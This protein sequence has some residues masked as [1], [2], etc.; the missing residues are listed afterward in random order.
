MKKQIVSLLLALVLV[1]SF[2]AVAAADVVYAGCVHHDHDADCGGLL[3]NCTYICDDCVAVAQALI[4]ALP[5]MSEIGDA[6]RAEVEQQMDAIHRALLP[7][8]DAAQMSMDMQ[9][10]ADAAFVLCT[11]PNFFGFA[12][13]K[14]YEVVDAN[15]PAPTISFLDENGVAATMYTASFQPLTAAELIPN[16]D[17]AYFYLPVGTYTVQEEVAGEWYMQLFVNGQPVQTVSGEEGMG[18]GVMVVNTYAPQHQ[19]T[20]EPGEGSGYMQP[21][22]VG[23]DEEYKYTLPACTF[24][25]PDGY[26]FKAWKV[27]GGSYN[28]DELAA[29][30][31]LE[32]I[33]FDITLTAQW[34][35]KG[36]SG[37]DDA[38]GGKP[39]KRYE[40]R[41]EEPVD[42]DV[43]VKSS[44]SYDSGV[45]IKPAPH[46]GFA[47]DEVTVT[48]ADGDRVPVTQRADG[49]YS[50]S[51]PRSS[52]TVSVSFAPLGEAVEIVMTI[53]SNIIRINDELITYDAAPQIRA[54]RT[55]LPI[56]IIAE[57]LGAEV[58]WDEPAQRVALSKD[59]TTIELFIGS[60]TVLINGQPDEL[61]APVFIEGGRTFL[62]VRLIA[63]RLGAEV[64]WDALQQQVTIS[65]R[66]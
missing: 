9:K 11:P 3:N 50:F 36:G 17:A 53:G 56:R 33:Y 38:D 32:D 4:D 35:P 65:G 23:F 8:S 44:A 1:F 57:A 48:T 18:Y 46:Y 15:N 52:V 39:A 19:I 21:A 20:L 5:P 61:E 28:G 47:V 29:G 59:D 27:V 58:V 66:K 64:E 31:T 13:Q 2:S 26:Q 30:V 7:L 24:T 10:Y 45:I 60:T 25:A 43:D 14:N 42:G 16:T 54:G 41:V 49:N 63:E 12:I 62:P 55:Y 6:N 51:M 22:E 37:V 40:I 34:I